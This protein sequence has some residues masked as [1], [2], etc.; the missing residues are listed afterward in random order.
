LVPAGRWHH[1][2]T[3]TT[4]T[5]PCSERQFVH[6]SEWMT[7][8]C[9]IFSIILTAVLYR[10]NIQSNPAAKFNP[11]GKYASC[12]GRGQKVCRAKAAGRDEPLIGWHT[13]RLK[14]TSL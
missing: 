9:L 10:T 8:F 2:S 5:N 13:G 11:S 7:N 14:P 4:G 1:D 3:G 6:I 12:T